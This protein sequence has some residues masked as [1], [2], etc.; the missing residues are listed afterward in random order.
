MD[1]TLKSRPDPIPEVKIW[2]FLI[3][4][5]EVF[6]LDVEKNPKLEHN[7][8]RTT[9]WKFMGTVSEA[10]SIENTIRTNFGSNVKVYTERQT[11]EQTILRQARLGKLPFSLE[12]DDG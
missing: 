11:E 10:N 1:Q 12:V 6:A 9:I 3:Q 5:G 8:N 7:G 4:G 2:T